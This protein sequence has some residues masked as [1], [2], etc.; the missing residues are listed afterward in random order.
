MRKLYI[1]ILVVF[2]FV[3]GCDT[4]HKSEDEKRQEAFDSLLRGTPFEGMT[5]REFE[6]EMRKGCCGDFTMEEVDSM[7]KVWD[8]LERQAKEAKK[9][10]EKDPKI[11]KDRAK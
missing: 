3:V 11:W 2:C 10:A 1:L 5:E 8:E 4:H 6:K 9:A 7:R